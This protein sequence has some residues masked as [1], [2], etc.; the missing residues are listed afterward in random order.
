MINRLPSARRHW[1]WSRQLQHVP[2]PDTEP[3]ASGC[4]SRYSL[5]KH[6]TI[7]HSYPHTG[8][9]GS[10]PE[11]IR[12][13]QLPEIWHQQEPNALCGISRKGG[14]GRLVGLSAL[15]FDSQ[16]TR[17]GRVSI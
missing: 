6:R 15:F 16:E 1:G 17:A 14:R 9:L 2:C 10:W 11:A 8:G 3:V 7:S 4:T 12:S 5:G 13:G